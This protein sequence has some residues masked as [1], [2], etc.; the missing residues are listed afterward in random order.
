MARRMLALIRL[1][2]RADKLYP[3]QPNIKSNENTN[4]MQHC[5]GFISAE[6]KPAQYCIKL[7]FSFDLYYD[8]RKHK[9]KK[10]A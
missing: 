6:I 10:K 9:I 8:A 7:V 5:A 2:C 1:V 4:L 3:K